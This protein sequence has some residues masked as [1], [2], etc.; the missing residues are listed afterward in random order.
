MG[1]AIIEAILWQKDE[2]STHSVDLFGWIL[3]C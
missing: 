2:D 3:Q 1:D